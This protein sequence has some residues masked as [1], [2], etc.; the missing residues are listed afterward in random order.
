MLLSLN[1][2]FSVFLNVEMELLSKIQVNASAIY[3]VVYVD[4][5][6][7]LNVMMDINLLKIINAPILVVY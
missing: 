4:L 1:I 3:P 6:F 2:L 7:A 5:E